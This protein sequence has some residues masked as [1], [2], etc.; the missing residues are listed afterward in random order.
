MAELW[1]GGPITLPHT[2]T[3]DGIELTIPE[4]PVTDL[5]YWLSTGQWWCLYPNGITDRA[6]AE[7][8]NER[9]NDPDDEFDMIHLHV[10]GTVLFGR[11]AGTA[12]PSGSGWWPAVRLATSALRHWP[13]FHAWCVGH[14]LDPLSSSLMTV[15]SAAY[16][17]LRETVPDDKIGKFENDLW[18]APATASAPAAEPEEL[19]E[20][21]RAQEAQMMLAAMN[22][23]LPGQQSFP[24]VY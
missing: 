8:L 20:H 5:L 1:P 23:S 14:A 9:L 7:P 15:I 4:F 21:I 24:G 17:W 2:L 6:A 12:P 3:H 16:A 18:A 11:L 19:P 10:V 22:E 13:L